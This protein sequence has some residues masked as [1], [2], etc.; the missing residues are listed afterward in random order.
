MAITAKQV[1]ARFKRMGGSDAEKE[2]QKRY[3]ELFE[4]REFFKAF[5]EELADFIFMEETAMKLESKSDKILQQFAKR[6]PELNRTNY[7]LA[8]AFSDF[9]SSLEDIFQQL[10]PSLL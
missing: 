8:R 9:H 3:N 1:V 7:L 6:H 10:E 2:A 5:D 4:E